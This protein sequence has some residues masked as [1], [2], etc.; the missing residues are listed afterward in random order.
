M[1]SIVTRNGHSKT[2]LRLLCMDEAN[3]YDGD[4]GIPTP[5][6]RFKSDHYGSF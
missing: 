2:R 5:Y 6:D 4:R 1:P 3:H